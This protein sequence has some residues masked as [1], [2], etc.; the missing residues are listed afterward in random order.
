MSDPGAKEFKPYV[1]ADTDMKELSLKALLLGIVMAVILGAANAYL[2]L[3]AGMT[4]AATFPAAVIAMA[5]LRPFKGTILE[6]NIARTTGAVGEALAAGAIFTIPAF[7]LTGLWTEFDYVI[8]TALLLVGGVLGVF[9]VIL[10]RRTFMEDASLP[11]PESQACTEIVKAGQK[12]SSGAGTVFAAMG[13]AALIEFFKNS[14]GITIIKENVKGAFTIGDKGA[15]PYVTPTSSPAFLGVGFIIGPKLS[16]ITAAGGVF[17]WMLL[18]PVALFVRAMFDSNTAVALKRLIAEGNW[19]GLYNGLS[20]AKYESLY[21]DAGITFGGLK[22][23][24]SDNIKMIAI[25][26]MI[27]AAFFTLYKMRSSLITGIG[28]SLKGIGGAGGAVEKRTE[29]DLNFKTVFIAIAVMLLLMLGLY[30]WLCESI[31]ISLITMIVMAIA[32]FL[33]AAVAGY[34]VSI[35]GSSSNP[36]SGLTLSTLLIAAGLLVILGM[37]GEKGTAAWAAGV[38][39]VLGVATVICC[40][41]GVAGDMIQDWKVGHNLGGTPWRMEISGVIGVIAAALVLVLPIMLLHEYGGGIGSDALPAPQ[42]GLMATMADGI[43]SGEM[44]WELIIIGMFFALALILIQSPSPMLIAVG[45][46]LPFQTTLAIFMGGII[47]WI[48]DSMVKKRA[49]KDKKVA[50]AVE[51]RGLLVASGLVAG[52]ALLG[53]LIAGLV[54]VGITLLPD[55]KLADKVEQAREVVAQVEQIQGTDDERAAQVAADPALLGRILKADN[56][57]LVKKEIDAQI[58]AGTPTDKVKGKIAVLKTVAD[59]NMV[60][61]APNWFGQ[62]WLGF[63]VI[64]GLGF[65]MIRTSLKAAKEGKGSGPAP[66]EGEGS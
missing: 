57:D 60:G 35:I 13:L 54:A 18:M 19:G 65:Y 59:T 14:N 6:E 15:F 8:S 56:P 64:I 31:G 21:G 28:R 41:A 26:A 29:K 43:I 44:A 24:Y 5:V 9:L 48:L 32:G 45:M 62:A 27:V 47:K 37:G 20:E 51:N 34:L 63:L 30:Y 12:G 66:P 52:E 4:V 50:E 25:G 11:F 17:G 61:R 22:G 36:I 33:F 58:S 38:L 39:A 7:I 46:Y 16:A 10:L 49:E 23:F 3:K 55:A 1:S 2:G 40:V 53:I 42:A